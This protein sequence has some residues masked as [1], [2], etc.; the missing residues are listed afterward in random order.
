M[1]ESVNDILKTVCDIEYTRHRSRVSALL[2]VFAGSCAY[3]FL[4]KFPSV[5]LNN[6]IQ[7]SRYYTNSSKIYYYTD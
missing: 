5:F 7:N 4:D 3:T 6:N 1:I 2:N